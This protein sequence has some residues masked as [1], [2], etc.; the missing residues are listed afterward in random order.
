[1]NKAEL[2]SAISQATGLKAGAAGAAIDALVT[3]VSRTL[4]AGEQVSIQG[5]GTWKVQDKPARV[6]INPKT[7]EK[8]QIKA[9]KVPKFVVGKPLK[10]AVDVEE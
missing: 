9:R 7:M 1:M 6:G 5:F 3:V 8:I 10:D 4:K 2:T